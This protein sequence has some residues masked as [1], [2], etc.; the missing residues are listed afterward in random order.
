M[1]TGFNW[2]K[3]GSGGLTP[4]TSQEA[5]EFLRTNSGGRLQVTVTPRPLKTSPVPWGPLAIDSVWTNYGNVPSQNIA[6]VLRE[7]SGRWYWV[8]GYI[9]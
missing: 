8:G 1:P 6:L 9:T 4:K 2:A 7:V 5:V 3:S